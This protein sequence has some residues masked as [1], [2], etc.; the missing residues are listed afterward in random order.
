MTFRRGHVDT[1]CVG[2]SQPDQRGPTFTPVRNAGKGR[3]G[4]SLTL[5]HT[6]TC[7]RRVLT[8]HPINAIEL[9]SCQDQTDVQCSSKV[10]RAGTAGPMRCSSGS[11][12]AS[13]Q[14]NPSHLQHEWFPE[15]CCINTFASCSAI[16]MP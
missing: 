4:R 1:M 13:F 15:V 14:S 11:P 6:T 10:L 5:S 7:S 12:L 8:R 9:S 2:Q 16:G 3:T